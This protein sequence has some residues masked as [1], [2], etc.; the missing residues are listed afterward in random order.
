M[1]FGAILLIAIGRPPYAALALAFFIPGLLSSRSKKQEL[2]KAFVLTCVTVT[3]TLA[4][5]IAVILA[6][7][8]ISQPYEAGG[9]VDPKMQLIYMLHHPHVVVPL[10]GY[11]VHQA[12]YYIAG[13]VGILGWLDT[14]M[15]APYYLAMLLV[16]VAAIVAELARGST[17][18]RRGDVLIPFAALVGVAGVFF[19]QYLV[20]TPVGGT[21]FYGVQ[22]RHL[23]PLL[24]VAAAGT[25][26]LGNSPKT[27]ERATA[28]VVLAQLLTVAVLPHIIT[29]R[30]YGS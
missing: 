2:L 30:Y 1:V 26:C 23:I 4:W 19:I 8:G 9:N 24:V 28:I 14:L 21:G 12:A 15:P 22:G 11:I 5:W 17:N 27:Y 25:P 16:L 29:A 6:T 3:I 13:V 18:P 7:R 10:L 20:F